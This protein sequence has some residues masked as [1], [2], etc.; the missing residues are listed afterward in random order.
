[1]RSDRPASFDPVAGVYDRLAGIVFGDT[2]HV[3]Q[4]QGLENLP[5]D[6]EIVIF[7]G[8]T[9][10]ILEDLLAA[11]PPFNAVHYVEASEKMTAR[12]MA[13][14]RSMDKRPAEGILRFYT[15][16]A[17]EWCSERSGCVDAVITP[18]FLDCFDGSELEKMILQIRSVLH[19]SGQWLITDFVASPKRK[20]RLVMATMFFFFRVSCG[21]RSRQLEPYFDQIEQHGFRSLEHREFA[22]PAGPVRSQRF[23]RHPNFSVDS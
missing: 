4:I 1:M 16:P 22:T 6:G 14:V 5:A 21:L 11:G 7:G 13:R 19:D 20:H 2:L 12:A 9:G 8:G 23:E 17:E 15:Q 18:F 3:A 10:R